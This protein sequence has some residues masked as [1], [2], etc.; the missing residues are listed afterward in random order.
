VIGEVGPEGVGV[1]RPPWVPSRRPPPR[2]PG[3][4]RG[5]HL[6]RCRKGSAKLSRTRRS[7]HPFAPGKSVIWLTSLRQRPTFV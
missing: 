1:P 5:Y 7:E 3:H 4:K 6:L 2:A